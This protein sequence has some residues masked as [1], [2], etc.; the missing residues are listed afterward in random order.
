MNKKNGFTLLEILL[1]LAISSVLLVFV[2]PDL[3]RTISGM[4]LPKAT[5]ELATA[6]RHSQ[7]QAINASVPTSLVLDVKERS[8]QLSGSEKVYQLPSDLDL[9]LLTGAGL[10][11]GG[12]SGTIHFYLDGSSSGGR[13]SLQKG[14]REQQI[15]INW[16]TGE[17]EIDN[18]V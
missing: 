16:L 8:Y 17:V 12:S 1:V 11:E 2:A 9:T 7:S 10:V 3:Y 4:S 13:I 15:H 6:L 14:E 18:E 5:Q